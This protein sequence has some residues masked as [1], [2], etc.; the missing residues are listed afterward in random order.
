MSIQDDEKARRKDLEAGLL[1][2]VECCFRCRF[3]AESADG[4]VLVCRRFPTT[5]DVCVN[6]VHWCGEF[7][8]RES[9]EIPRWWG[10]WKKPN[11]EIAKCP[12][13]PTC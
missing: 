9:P 6:L 5:N 1:P 3:V 12:E 2:G 8:R 11:E 13:Q 10:N 4:V 7:Q